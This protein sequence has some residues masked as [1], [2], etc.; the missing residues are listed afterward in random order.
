VVQQINFAG[1][2]DG[3]RSGA[4]ED[5]ANI[6]INA[7]GQIAF[8]VTFTTGETAVVVAA[9]PTPSS[10]ALVLPALL[11]ALRCRPSRG[12]LCL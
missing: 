9:V 6:G 7:A 10:S 1:A 2:F 5:G 8:G 12:R 11:G 3:V 4:G